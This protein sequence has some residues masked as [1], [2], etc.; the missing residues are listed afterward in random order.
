MPSSLLPGITGGDI[1]P[2]NRKDFVGGILGLPAWAPGL[3]R[4][5][6]SVGDGCC[7]R[8]PGY[9]P[10]PHGLAHVTWPAKLH[11]P[12]PRGLLPGVGAAGE[13]SWPLPPAWHG[14]FAVLSDGQGQGRQVTCCPL[15][16]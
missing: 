3:W 11:P 15:P 9:L 4:R 14:G 7:E 16:P 1:C 2:K 8:P 5:G 13:V 6:A 12:L 10:P